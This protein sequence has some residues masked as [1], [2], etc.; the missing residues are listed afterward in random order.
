MWSSV[1][2]MIASTSELKAHAGYAKGRKRRKRAKRR[3]IAKRGMGLKKGDGDNVWRIVR[4]GGN[5]DM[6]R[7]RTPHRVVESFQ[8]VSVLRHHEPG[9]SML[10]R[11]QWQEKGGRTK[12]T[13]WYVSLARF[14]LRPGH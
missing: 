6:E 3:E 1:G 9:Q 4:R 8:E 13:G 10:E 7:R 14:A 11:G 12:K 5:V 2:L